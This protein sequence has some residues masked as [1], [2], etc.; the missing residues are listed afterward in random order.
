MDRLRIEDDI[1]NKELETP[2][3]DKM[4]RVF[5]KRIDLYNRYLKGDKL[6]DCLDRITLETK[7]DWTMSH[8]LSLII[9]EESKKR[10]RDLTTRED[11]L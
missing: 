4:I 6:N 8:L 1:I 11:R 10:H 2:I 9:E 5:E 3:V 7:K